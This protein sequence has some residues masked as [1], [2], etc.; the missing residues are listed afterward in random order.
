M[1]RVA[2]LQ[3][4]FARHPVLRQ[5][6]L[7]KYPDVTFK[8]TDDILEGQALVDFIRGHDKVIMSIDWLKRRNAA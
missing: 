4:F 6:L 8:E 3:A 2:V 5:E 1:S 7:A